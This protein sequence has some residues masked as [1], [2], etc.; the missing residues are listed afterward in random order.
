MPMK[1]PAHPGG[2]LKRQYLN[3]LGLSITDAAKALGVTRKTVSELVNG[4]SGVSPEMALRLSRAFN[5]TPE[6]WINMQR[7]RDL[8]IAKQRFK[9]SITPLWEGDPTAVR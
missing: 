9:A 3:P 5:T 4:H 6:F 8:W 1:D 2:Y 7:N